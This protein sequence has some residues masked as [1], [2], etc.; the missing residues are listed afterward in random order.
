MSQIFYMIR[1]G[2]TDWNVQRRLQGHSDIALNSNGEQQ[3][4]TL[5]ENFKVAVSKVV[6]SDLIRA[7][8]TAKLVFPNREI[9]TT[10]ALREVHLGVA[11]GLT[12]EIL[13]EQFG[14]E[15]W[16]SWG[17]H[18]QKYLDHQFPQGESKRQILSRVLAGL[19][20]HLEKQAVNELPMVFVSHGLVMR[21]LIHSLEPTRTET[22]FVP[23][24]G[25]LK[26]KY[27]QNQF[28]LLDAMDPPTLITENYE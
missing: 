8:Q 9:S 24:C 20:S 17:S 26:L 5:S 19:Q 23:N 14:Q 2:E 22:R 12:R 16:D 13:I 10:P 7:H 11:E 21:T 3:A 25:V 4:R 18:D 28:Q 15:F 27:H 6:S 1:H